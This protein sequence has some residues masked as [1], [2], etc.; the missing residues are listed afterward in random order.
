MM[1][2]KRK[3][4]RPRTLYTHTMDPWC[5]DVYL[6]YRFGYRSVSSKR[7]IFYTCLGD[8]GSDGVAAV[9]VCQ[10]SKMRIMYIRVKSYSSVRAI[11][12]IPNIGE[13]R[14]TEKTDRP[15]IVHHRTNKRELMPQKFTRKTIRTH[16][17]RY[18]L[19]QQ[20]RQEYLHKPRTTE[21]KTR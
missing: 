12:L 18:F 1:Y 19:Y 20:F 8:C 3:T 11:R 4:I 9:V 5:V 2:L 17:W 10:H 16:T 6:L 21:M 13:E 7:D 14:F 15:T